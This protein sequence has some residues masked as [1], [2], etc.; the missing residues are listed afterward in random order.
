MSKIRLHGSSSGYTE[1]APVAAS[2]NNTLTLP[3]DGTILSKDSN[4]AVGVTSI[5]VGTGVTIGDGRVTCTTVH[6]SAASL[7][8]IPAA[9]IV[10][11]ATAGF[12]RSGGFGKIL[13]VV[14]DTKTDTFTTTSASDVEV[15]GLSVSITPS[16]SSNKVLLSVH[17]G[18][19]GGDQNAYAGFT[20]YRDIG[21]SSTDLLVG[22][23]GGG[24][25]PSRTFAVNT[26]ASGTYNATAGSF[27]LLDSPN[28]TSEI[29]YKIKVRSGYAT[30]SIYINRYHT[31][32][33]QNYTYRSASTYIATEVSA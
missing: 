1:I 17:L 31:N 24:S 30:K 25:R 10:G 7:T 16:S 28:T 5:T 21:G 9:N 12:N 13:Q 11:L 18:L 6:G 14:Q 15:T 29:T 23:S 26:N 27:Q 22:D 8:S 32:D 4:G 20:L 2:G 33:D 19:V 3:D